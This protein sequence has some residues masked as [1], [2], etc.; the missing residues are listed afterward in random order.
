MPEER[1]RFTAAAVSSV[2]RPSTHR[3][4]TL[5]QVMSIAFF[6]RWRR[7]SRTHMSIFHIAAADR[8]KI[9]T[10]D[11]T[12]SFHRLSSSTAQLFHQKR[13]RHAQC[14]VVNG[15]PQ[16]SPELS[17]WQQRHQQQQRQ[18]Q[19]RRSTTSRVQPRSSVPNKKPRESQQPLLKCLLSTAASMQQNRTI[20]RSDERVRKVLRA[21][22][23]STAR[24][25]LRSRP[26]GRVARRK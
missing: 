16:P 4:R 20:G 11:L 15:P 9:N 17:Q 21:K 1:H 12:L 22:V 7:P 8:S 6:C 14:L 2:C 19:K 24:Y 26:S 5:S 23:P 3:H 13:P 10:G 25:L 18:Q